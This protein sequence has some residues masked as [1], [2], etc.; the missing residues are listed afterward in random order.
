MLQVYKEPTM[1][2]SHNI[3]LN[4]SER[5]RRAFQE[6]GVELQLGFTSFQMDEENPH[7]TKISLLARD[8]QAVDTAA[9][10]FSATELDTAKH[11]GLASS[12]HRGYPEPSDDRGYLQA[13]FDLTHYCKIC[14]IG[15]RQVA[16]FR[17][18]KPPIWGSKSILQLNWIFDEY[19]VKPD[20][21]V[22]IFQPFGIGHRP[23][24]LSS[25][26]V[27][28]DSVVQLDIPSV[29]DLQLDNFKYDEC[30]SCGQKKYLPVSR[31]FYPTPQ[32]SVTSAFKSKQY[33]GSGA[34][35]NKLVLVSSDLF[36]R[37]KKTGLKGV[38]FKP[39][40]G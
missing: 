9:T 10:K 4:V 25:T 23:V 5:T 16:P 29:V 33:F 13:T 2:I 27:E 40:A 31:G 32:T 20:V 34:S 22:A 12:W 7:W 39:C 14:G 37:I 1:K 18:K 36:V 21:W 11:L 6:F 17:M 8:F 26:S 30:R 24:L 38:D 28:I 3:A 15:K 35:A 19:F